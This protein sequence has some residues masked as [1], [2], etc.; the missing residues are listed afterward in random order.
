MVFNMACQVSYRVRQYD[1]EG[2]SPS[3]RDSRYRDLMREVDALVEVYNDR[4]PDTALAYLC[5]EAEV[6][7][8]DKILLKRANVVPLK[9][10][11][12]PVS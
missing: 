1:E 2:I 5:G 8:R 9:R 4:L 10:K 7:K 11:G 6:T 3:V 12:R